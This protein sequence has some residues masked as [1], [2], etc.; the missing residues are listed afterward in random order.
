MSS[1]SS[2][3]TV[4]VRTATAFAVPV[5]DMASGAVL[6]A[7]ENASSIVP[8]ARDDAGE[9][10]EM[11][12]VD[13]VPA[14]AV[15][16]SAIIVLPLATPVEGEILDFTYLAASDHMFVRV[17][18]RPQPRLTYGHCLAFSDRTVE[19]MV[20]IGAAISFCRSRT[21]WWLNRSWLTCCGILLR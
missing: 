15:Q 6:R 9:Y 19:P 1:S 17:N 3:A 13:L 21:T 8:G 7:V 4:P 14:A 16:N 12:L 11:A 20:P 18:C 5:Y 2:F 10:M